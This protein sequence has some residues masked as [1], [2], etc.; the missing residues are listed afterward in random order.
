MRDETRTQD[1]FLWDPRCGE[2][3]VQCIACQ[4]FGRKPEAPLCVLKFRFEEM[5]PLLEIDELGV[6][7]H[8]R[9]ATR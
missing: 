2:W 9:T 1:W 6:C 5:F 8:C 4:Q 7:Q 3:I